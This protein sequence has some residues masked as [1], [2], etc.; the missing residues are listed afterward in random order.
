MIANHQIATFSRFKNTSFAALLLAML[1]FAPPLSAQPEADENQDETLGEVVNL[2]P[3]EISGEDEPGYLA[4]QTLAGTRL[5][6]DIRDVAASISIVTKRFLE[7]TG[8]TDINQLF[9]Y[10]SGTETGGE[11][12]NFS[13]AEYSVGG[14]DVS[15]TDLIRNPQYA[16]R[17][18][19]LAPPDLTRDYF[20]TRIP[21]DSYNTQ[22]FEINRGANAI[23]FGLG[24]PVGIV[25]DVSLEPYFAD[26][27]D[28]GGEV[29]LRVGERGSLRTSLDLNHE[30]IDEKLAV[31]VALLHDKTEY[32]QRPSFEEDQRIYGAATWKPFKHTTVKFNGEAGD[33]NANRPNPVSAT[34]N[35][36]S[37]ILSGNPIADN[38]VFWNSNDNN[39][40][41][42]SKILTAP[43]DQG[44]VP[45][46]GTPDNRMLD[47]GLGAVYNSSDSIDSGRRIWPGF[48]QF[49]TAVMFSDYDLVHSDGSI[50]HLGGSDFPNSSLPSGPH[51]LD[52]EPDGEFGSEILFYW[53]IDQSIDEMYG[54]GFAK[55]GLLDTRVFDWIHNNLAGDTG[56]QNTDFSTYNVSFEQT[57]LN[58]HAGIEFVFDT[59]EVSELHF[60]PMQLEYRNGIRIDVNPVLPVTAGGI[61]Q[62]NPNFLRPYYATLIRTSELDDQRD[63]YRVTGFFD[64]DLREKLPTGLGNLLGHHV[65][66]GVFSDQTISTDSVERTARWKDHLLL[67]QSGSS[68]NGTQALVNSFVYLGPPVSLDA[69][70]MDDVE[71][72]RLSDGLQLYRP[73]LANPITHWDAGVQPGTTN[74]R[75][76]GSTADGAQAII[77]L[78]GP[79]GFGNI[80]SRDV[81]YEM[82]VADAVFREENIQSYALT[83][84]SH[85]LSDHFVGTV[86][87]RRDEVTV[88]QISGSDFLLDTF[89]EPIIAGRSA[90]DDST[91]DR[92]ADDTVSWGI[93][94]HWPN[95][96]IE[97]PFQSQLSF[98]Y[99]ESS[100]FQPAVGRTDEMGNSLASPG[101]NTEELGFSLAMFENKV[102]ARVNWYKT[103]LVNAPSGVVGF[104]N[105]VHLFYRWM[106][107]SAREAEG[108][109]LATGSIAAR[110]AEVLADSVID[111]MWDTQ[112]KDVQ[113][114]YNLMLLRN[115]SG[116]VI[117]ETHNNPA[118]LADT[119]DISAKGTEVELVFNPTRNWRLMLNLTRQEAVRSNI[120]PVSRAWSDWVRNMLDTPIPGYGNLTIGELPEGIELFEFYPDETGPARFGQGFVD[121]NGTTINDHQ[122]RTAFSALRSALSQ[123]GAISPELREWRLNFV[124]NYEFS[125]GRFRGLTLGGAWRYQS[126]GAVGY[127]LTDTTGDGTPDAS[128]VNNPYFAD[129]ESNF[130]FWTSYEMPFFE[131]YGEWTIGLSVRNAFTDDND[132]VTVLT[133]PNGYVARVRYAPPREFYFSS[134]FKF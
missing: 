120:K 66:T 23:L 28:T 74:Q 13:A 34:E 85:V 65:F 18:R 95:E 101:G 38:R 41:S 116:D 134:K 49:M 31:R 117:G 37:W 46:P 93:V 131:K 44:G 52:T 58:N 73:G 103:N 129:S 94:A 4:T 123:E 97:L 99:G 79:D 115:E 113:E 1:F 54:T 98:H 16:T 80:M 127:Q 17:V 81:P 42:L 130:D 64:L 76:N 104:G 7:D 6:S 122:E 105:A 57:F 25:N 84:Q 111:L 106:A 36:S 118:Q 51:P 40:R 100:N 77:D 19:G 11:M 5:R 92:I 126:K 102:F 20:L 69:V 86:G 72:H 82:I 132:V 67:R 22:R 119:E 53:S 89:G 59:Q 78:A 62:P 112:P 33:I 114:N 70:S 61:N 48:S 3:F 96:I 24:S 26:G 90:L 83:S 75:A 91:P 55:P 68:I 35:I 108:N 12:G 47:T 87:W 8:V 15:T 45:H 71:V 56:F 121:R 128:D 2:S 14:G 21:F 39:F 50:D 109:W 43:L 110:E 63:A 125:E 27:S 124:T 9:A 29:N 88:H 32:Q 107:D 60:T 10:T 133:Q 30:L